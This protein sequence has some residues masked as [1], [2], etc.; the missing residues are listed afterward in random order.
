MA[1]EFAASIFGDPNPD[2]A[3][4]SLKSLH[5]STMPPFFDSFF[6]PGQVLIGLSLMTTLLMTKMIIR[7]QGIKLLWT[8]IFFFLDD[9]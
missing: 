2:M 4:S 8:S 1:D 9:C 5:H 7:S 6:T 3:S